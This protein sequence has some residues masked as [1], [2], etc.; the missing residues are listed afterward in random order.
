MEGVYFATVA[1]DIEQTLYGSGAG[2]F[3]VLSKGF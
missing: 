1:M 2:A 3:S